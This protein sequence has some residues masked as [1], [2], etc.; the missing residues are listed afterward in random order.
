VRFPSLTTAIVLSS[1][2]LGAQSVGVTTGDLKGHVRIAGT[3]EVPPGIALKLQNVATGEGR[4]ATAN[5]RGE[6][7]FRILPAGWYVLTA[8]VSPL[9][10]SGTSRC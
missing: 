4:T 7:G 3:Q 8:E 6:Y 5:E 1:L 10:V 2:A 9:G